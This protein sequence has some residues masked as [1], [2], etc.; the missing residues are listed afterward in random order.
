MPLTM[1]SVRVTVLDS[2]RAAHE[3]LSFGKESFLEKRRRRGES[4]AFTKAWDE[5]SFI[6]GWLGRPEAELLF[7]LAAAVPPGREHRRGGLV[8]RAFDSVPGLGRRARVH[9]SFGRPAHHGKSPAQAQ[10]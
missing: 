4:T 9:G 5:A 10:S 3:G 8:P 2:V 7:E 1:R 6:G